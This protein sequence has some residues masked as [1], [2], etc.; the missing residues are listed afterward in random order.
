MPLSESSQAF[1]RR[2]EPAFPQFQYEGKELD[3]FCLAVG[4]KD[5][6]RT[7]LRD[8]LRGDILEVGAGIGS[9]TRTL[10]HENVFRW[11]ALDP[12]DRHVNALSQKIQVLKLSKCT[13]RL[14]KLRDLK[15]EEKFDVILYLD[16]LEHIDNDN[17]ELETAAKH[18]TEYGTLVVLAP[19]HGWL[20]SS[21]DRYIGHVRRYTRKTLRAAAPQGFHLVLNRYLDSAGLLV[22]AGNRFLL[23]SPLP[24]P[25]QILFW[26]RIL[27]PLSRLVDRGTRY[28]F[29]K[30]LLMIWKRRSP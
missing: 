23:R 6:V 22:S 15:P 21:F 20:Y 24:S 13:A 11:T 3:A 7:Q 4:W 17:E 30:S 14:G 18:L 8:F 26:D 2:P 12:D 25:R 16:V 10:Y 28:N 27:V 19:A 5:Y 29:G 9:M 1:S